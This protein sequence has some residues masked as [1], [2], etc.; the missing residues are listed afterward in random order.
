MKRWLAF[1]IILV[2][3][4]SVQ[5]Q[6]VKKTLDKRHYET[7]VVSMSQFPQF[8]GLPIAELYF[9]AY[10][11][12]AHAWR[13][14]PFQ[15]DDRN[16]NGS[17]FGWQTGILDQ[18]DELVFMA[19]DLGDRVPDG[20]WLAD[21]NSRLTLRYE[22]EL[23]DTLWQGQRAWGY[24]F[25][26]ATITSFPAQDYINYSDQ[27]ADANVSD[28][29]ISK[30]YETKFWRDNGLPF[31]YTITT[32]GG[33]N[34]IEF[35]DRI[36]FR[37]QAG[38]I[39]LYGVSYSTPINVTEDN[40]HRELVQVV[41]SRVRVIRNMKA[42]IRID[43]FGVYTYEDSV[44]MPIYFYPYNYNIKSSNI[45]LDTGALPSG[46]SMHIKLIR[47]STD[48]NAN[49]NGMIFYNAYNRYS[50]DTTDFRNLVNGQGGSNILDHTLDV[51]GLNWFMI[52]GEPGTIFS[53]TTVPAIGD[54]QLVY[55]W[56]Y[57]YPNIKTWDNTPDT[58][59]RH[60]WGDSG[61]W[62]RGNNISGQF[63][64]ISSTYFLPK[65]LPVEVGDTLDA[66]I[67]SPPVIQVQPQGYDRTPPAKIMA[68]TAVPESD[69]AITLIWTAPGDDST[70]GRAMRYEIRYSQY[71]PIPR[72][73]DIWFDFAKKVVV[74]PTPAT[75]GVEEHLTITGLLR[76]KTYY[77]AIR[78]FDEANNVSQ[79]SDFIHQTSL[80]VE[81]VSFTAQVNADAVEVSW[82][83]VSEENN[84]GFELQRR[85]LKTDFQTIAFI[86]GHGTTAEPHDYFFLDNNI[87]GDNPIYRLKQIDLDGSVH[88]SQE[89]QVS[90]PLPVR[91]ELLQNYPNPFN[92]TTILT[93]TLADEVPV[94]LVV[95]NLN[96]QIVAS[97]VKSVQPAGY[98]KVIV[99]A[100]RWSA[101]IY[102]ARL[103]AGGQV[104]IKKMILLE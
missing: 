23:N 79:Y 31:E 69:S 91:F 26:S 95:Y 19:R 101:G 100:S 86:A 54:Q 76:N 17:Y 84:Y 20:Y 28:K 63:S 61:I 48:L 80:A 37:I 77:F 56:D 90:V 13:P 6:V 103:Q 96:G 29:V 1:F 102:F 93:Y 85:F 12:T 64:L 67:K 88:L 59:D 43:A 55:F 50:P 89:I 98:Y 66:N 10:D 82:R 11:S 65:N 35:L 81:L 25:H 78:T 99:D 42:N 47:I 68:V 9:Y 34:N 53:T 38:D 2:F 39:K 21:A 3:S 83:T 30:Y 71:A 18:Y 62:I 97:L 22:V 52:T 44:Y 27:D 33:G 51:P 94:D 104:F 14:V 24:L 32:D 58:G 46:V 72:D 49:A 57:N 16:E 73:E 45:S 4:L 92:P 75:A 7:V 74:L 8:Q 15:I 60:S 41:D 36:K 70:T 5:A 87:A 40:I